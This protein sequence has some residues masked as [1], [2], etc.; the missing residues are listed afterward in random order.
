MQS[1]QNFGAHGSAAGAATA[2]RASLEHVLGQTQTPQEFCVALA[3]LFGVRLTEVALL[4]L[5]KGLLK[6]AY[7]EELKTAGAI[8]VSSSSAIASHTASSKKVELFNAFAKVKH[9]RVFETVKLTSKEDAEKSEQLQIQ[10]LMS[11][12]ILDPARKVIGVVQV[13]RK[14]FDLVSSGPDFTQDDLQQLEFATVIACK[15]SFMTEGL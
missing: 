3:K 7:P 2:P 12:P 11:A 6:F 1:K 10:K 15:K 4:R 5:E 13:C 8:P 9:A 14:G